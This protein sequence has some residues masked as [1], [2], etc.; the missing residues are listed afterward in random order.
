MLPWSLH[1]VVDR[2]VNTFMAPSKPLDADFFLLVL[3]C[4]EPNH[5]WAKTRARVEHV[6]ARIDLFRKGQR[7]R[8]SGRT[9]ITVVIGLINFVHNLRRLVTMVRLQQQAHATG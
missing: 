6:F 7:L 3:V 5:R 1:A 8:C 4:A 2:V 9:R